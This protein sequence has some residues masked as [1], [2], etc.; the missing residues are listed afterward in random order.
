MFLQLD[1]NDEKHKLLYAEICHLDKKVRQ[2]KGTSKFKK[3]SEELKF[4]HLLPIET[5][6]LVPFIFFFF[7]L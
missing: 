3:Y 4:I 1:R 7:Y 2:G 5:I 6:I